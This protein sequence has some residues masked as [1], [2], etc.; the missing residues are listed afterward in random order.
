[1]TK[2]DALMQV[3]EEYVN[4]WVPSRRAALRAAIEQALSEEWENGRCAGVEL[5]KQA[6][7]DAVAQERERWFALLDNPPK[8]HFW[9]AGELD[10]PKELKAA[11]G[12]LHTLRCKVCGI[13]SPRNSIC[14][15]EIRKGTP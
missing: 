7:E 6:L 13:T 12:E 11:N 15:A 10:C 8:H 4:V 3:V 2:T 1:M 9:M 14:T 5:N